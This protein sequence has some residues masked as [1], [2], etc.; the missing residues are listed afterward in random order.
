MKGDATTH[1]VYAGR[2]LRSRD[3]CHWRVEAWDER[4]ATAVSPP[5]CWTMGLLTARAWRAR[6]IAGDPE[7]WRRDPA[8][9]A[10]SPTEPGTPAWFR[11]EF[12]VP[13]AVRR[14]TL[15]ASARGLFE[16]RLDGRRVGEDLFAP[17]WTDY[18]RRIHYRTYDVTGLVRPGANVLGAVLGDGWWSG[19]VG[20][21]ETRGR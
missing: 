5:A 9:T 7:I 13:G 12:T 11:R 18:H 16:L 2:P 19:F 3:V 21:Q 10:A 20:W 1:I 14:A 15:Y 17:E 4:G 6:W 8:A